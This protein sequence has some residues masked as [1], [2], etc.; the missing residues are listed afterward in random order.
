MRGEERE[1]EEAK[2]QAPVPQPFYAFMPPPP[3]NYPP[4]TLQGA[5]SYFTLGLQQQL[6]DQQAYANPEAPQMPMMSNSF[7]VSGNQY[8]QFIP[9]WAEMMPASQPIIAPVFDPNQASYQ[10]VVYSV[11][12][13]YQLSTAGA[14]LDQ[15]QGEY[16]ERTPEMRPINS[17][18]SVLAEQNP[19]FVTYPDPPELEIPSTLLTVQNKSILIPLHTIG[20][21]IQ[22]KIGKLTIVERQAKIERFRQKRSRRT[23]K[24]RITYGCR[25]DL[26]DKRG[27]CKGR[28]VKKAYELQLKNVNGETTNEAIEKKNI[29]LENTPQ[30]VA[31]V[32][33]ATITPKEEHEDPASKV[34]AVSH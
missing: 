33:P 28:F 19:R 20:Q 5:V 2:R 26:A 18:A 8:P 30:S 10:N 13:Q 31:Q 7:I 11:N 4:Y 34:F 3:P 22:K 24:K 15:R 25:K 29:P 17:Y 12:P 1:Y 6:N 32:V 23:W 16:Y 14:E 9:S 21:P 27:R